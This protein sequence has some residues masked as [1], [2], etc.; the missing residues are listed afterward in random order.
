MSKASSVPSS[1]EQASTTRLPPV[2][3]SAAESGKGPRRRN[4]T[5]RAA[6][7]Q[8]QELLE[9]QKAKRSFRCFLCSTFHPAPEVAYHTWAFASKSH[10]TSLRCCDEMYTVA[11]HSFAH[12]ARLLSRRHVVCCYA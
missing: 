5:E 9:Q 12:C 11:L 7:Q 4:R 8:E 3:S 2:A 1:P 10:L 6:L